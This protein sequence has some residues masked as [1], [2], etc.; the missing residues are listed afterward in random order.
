[1]KPFNLVEWRAP[2]KI[3]LLQDIPIYRHFSR[4]F[5]LAQNYTFHQQFGA[6]RTTARVFSVAAVS[7]RS[8]FIN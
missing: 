5:I 1:M 2:A 4:I 3:W 6:R 8:K 7:E